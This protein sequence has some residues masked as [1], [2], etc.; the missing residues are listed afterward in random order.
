MHSLECVMFGQKSVLSLCSCHAVKV[1]AEPLELKFA[2]C[3]E[4]SIHRNSG[5]IFANLHGQWLHA[6][7]P[8]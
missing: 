4:Q 3:A 5:G 2:A 6:V 7:D 8:T 1:L